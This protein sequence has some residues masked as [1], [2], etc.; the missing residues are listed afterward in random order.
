MKALSGRIL[1][2]LGEPESSSD[3]RFGPT[4]QAPLL[5]ARLC[6]ENCDR[7]LAFVVAHPS[8]NFMHHH[9]LE[10]LQARG[11]ACLALN[12]RY[13]GN[14]ANL[15]MERSIQD[16][17]KGVAFLRDQGYQRI[18]L[19]GHSGGG[20]LATFYQAEAEKL[21]VTSLP[22]GTPFSIKQDD[23][24][25]ADGIVLL[26]AHPGRAQV[27]TGW[28]DPSVI[29]EADPFSCDPDLDMFNPENGPPYAPE[30]IERYRAAQLARNKRI[31]DQAMASLRMLERR[32]PSLPPVLDKPLV[33]HRTGADPR[34]LDLALDPNGRGVQ[35]IDAARASNYAHDNMARISS[36][37]SWLSQWSVEF[38]RADGPACL[39]RTTVPVLIVRYGA[40]QIV[41]P[42][43]TGEWVKAAGAR[44]TFDLLPGA[45]HFLGGQED[46][47]LQIADRL[48]DWAR[49]SPGQADNRLRDAGSRARS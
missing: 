7:S 35:N 5:Y 44:G 6:N 8:A 18:I 36:L 2:L 41:F 15:M 23:L 40:D 14:D 11:A 13:V 26:A 9:L 48:L 45:N 34:F 38:S 10:Q 21:T 22:D 33:V 16:L 39:A 24:P 32:R 30:W 3:S 1:T 25:P 20:S 49:S 46:L 12:T 31:S 29:D 47:Q 27:L 43:Q 37:R 28:L 4:A 17:G 42:S 19:V